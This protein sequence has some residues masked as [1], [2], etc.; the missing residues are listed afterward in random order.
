MTGTD[1]WGSLNYVKYGPPATYYSFKEYRFIL[2]D[3]LESFD[4]DSDLYRVDVDVFFNGGTKALPFD[5]GGTKAVPFDHCMTG[6]NPNSLIFTSKILEKHH[7]NIPVASVVVIPNDVMYSSELWYEVL[8]DKG[9]INLPEL[10]INALLEIDL[11]NECESCSAHMLYEAEY[12]PVCKENMDEFDDESCG[13]G[14]YE[15][16][17]CTPPPSYSDLIYEVR[18]PHTDEGGATFRYRI[19][20]EFPTGTIPSAP[21]WVEEGRSTRSFRNTCGDE[22]Y[23]QAADEIGIPFRDIHPVIAMADFYVLE[24]LSHG[25]PNPSPIKTSDLKMLQMEAAL[26]FNELVK[27][28]DPHFLTYAIIAVGG[29]VRHMDHLSSWYMPK[30]RHTAWIAFSHI[31][32]EH[33]VEAMD[34]AIR[35]LNEYAHG[36]YGGKKWGAV[37]EC[38]KDRMSGR[39]TPAQWLDRV[40]TLCHNNGSIFNKIVWGSRMSENTYTLN[41]MAMQTIGDYHHSISVPWSSLLSF[42]SNEVRSLFT[43][44]WRKSNRARGTVACL[45]HAPYL[46]AHPMSGLQPGRIYA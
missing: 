38:T 42:C 28:H 16:S 40:F 29:E 15:C 44:Y 21:P 2:L 46:P 17:Y 18:Y 30:N 20:P 24:A 7:P 4:E 34:W 12:C 13:C 26:M 45:A 6:I 22:T 10:L 14:E 35:V 11:I 25:I 9:V 31:V 41:M 37:A 43:E 23:Q 19:H 36:G 3:D 33:G 1:S 32:E 39:I 27:I 5:H 8:T